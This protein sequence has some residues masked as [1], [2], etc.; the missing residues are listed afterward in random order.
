VEKRLDK[1]WDFPTALALIIT[2]WL[3]GL[4]IE[5]TEW[6]QYLYVVSN[7][8]ILGGIL[9]MLLGA[10]RY[11]KRTAF[12]YLL[13]ITF[14]VI[15]W[16]LGVTMKS[17]P[18]W[19]E[20][21]QQLS[22][23]TVFTLYQLS[24]SQPVND[25]VLFLTVLALVG[26]LIGAT[27]GFSLVR[28]GRPYLPLGA[29]VLGT[30]VV[31][32]FQ[33]GLPRPLIDILV[34]VLVIFILGRVGFLQADK[35][36]RI[37][38]IQ[39]DMDLGFDMGR[40]VILIG[41]VLVLVAWYFPTLLKVFQAD[42]PERIRFEQSMTAME[43]TFNNF[44][45]PL[46]RT[47]GAS[48]VYTDQLE[49]G[50][51]AQ[52]GTK[53][54]YVVQASDLNQAGLKFYWRIRIYDRYND[55]VWTD[56]NSLIR[57]L[58]PFQNMADYPEYT[59]RQKISFT[60]QLKDQTQDQIIFPP[61]PK[62][63]SR[64]VDVLYLLQDYK[65]VDVLELTPRDS[66]VNTYL[67]QGS[68]A[69]P[70]EDDLRKAGTDYPIY[71]E[72]T[73]LQIPAGFPERM[74]RLAE[75]I[76]ADQTNPFDK[77][78]AITNYLRTNIEYRTRIQ[79]PP[80]DR[81]PLDWFLFDYKQG[82]CN[83]YASAEV[84]LLRSIGIPARLVVGYVQGTTEGE[85]TYRVQEND[86]HAWPEVFFP[87]VG[88]VELEP[89]TSQDAIVYPKNATATHLLGGPV[90]SSTSQQTNT[91]NSTNSTNRFNR[92]EEEEKRQEALLAAAAE[93]RRVTT[94]VSICL[95]VLVLDLSALAVLHRI[96][97][98]K[99]WITL[100]ERVETVLEKRGIKLPRWLIL[101]IRSQKKSPM[102]KAFA[103]VDWALKLS[104]H[105]L[106]AG[107]TPAQ[108]VEELKKWIPST[109]PVADILLKEYQLASYSP[110]AY[111]EAVA[112]QAS[113]SIY[114]LAIQDKMKNLI[115]N[116]TA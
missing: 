34:L 113:R 19:L 66:N 26:W 96:R 110:Y 17:Y 103:V 74:T 13:D 49:L 80:F 105:G 46:K 57:A 43:H 1:W 18:Q 101:M 8:L 56:A 87:G 27:A 73:Y 32:F 59:D 55:G 102:E 88:W 104:R 25:P 6:T 109:A 99:K 68:V 116:L 83:Y 107:A 54:L 75:Q 70:T 44:V 20:R 111:N 69:A 4:R 14:F 61:Q 100:L 94:I 42:T 92:A 85:K 82:F 79:P 71:V 22:I 114:W 63:I 89:T 30:F 78:I 81:D 77:A 84:M 36:W 95:V 10:S 38:N 37:R 29:V 48:Y 53:P 93:K 35:R 11:R 51:S 112:K 67:V 115:R 47:G 52:L 97:K 3:M 21:L 41:L 5:A 62:A 7:L 12:L 45:A 33:P 106:E 108:Q 90:P 91:L 50:T 24:H 15:P 98:G 31:E 40:G 9:G 39:V 23:R 86:R 28:S 2:L 60:I 64:S 72:N 65:P 16:Q 58:D 76:S